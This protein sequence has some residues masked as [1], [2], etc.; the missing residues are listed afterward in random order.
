MELALWRWSTA[1]QLTSLAMITVF[2]AVLARSVRLVELRYWVR[3]WTWGL[4]AL[5]VT[6]LFWFLQPGPAFFALARAAYMVPKTAFVLLLIQGRWALKNP[7]RRLLGAPVTVG[8]LGAYAIVAALLPD[9][10]AVLGTVQHSLMAVLFAAGAILL[11][12]PPLERGLGWLVAG[13]SVRALLCSIEAAAYASQLLAEGTL[14]PGLQARAGVFL[15]A[16]SS[17]DSGA[18]WLLALGCV[19]AISERAQRELRRTNV[20]LQTAQEELRR[21]ADRDPLT[22][23][24]N[25]RSLPEVFRAVQPGGATLALDVR[26]GR[27]LQSQARHGGGPAGCVSPQVRSPEP[28]V[29]LRG[30]DDLHL[31]GLA[32]RVRVRAHLLRRRPPPGRPD[33][34][35]RSHSQRLRRLPR[36]RRAAFDPRRDHGRGAPVPVPCPR[37]LVAGGPGQS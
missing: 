11:A 6:L 5:V 15:A 34:R 21:L 28:R 16:H 3:A 12:R 20:D 31:D 18:E 7:G 27:V 19:L 24:S 33:R 26:S 9:S 30:A 25:R 8:A 13:F 23:L 22:A 10:V 36:H 14:A 32:G 4:I 29:D 37:Q 2:F 35:R 17:F 1:V